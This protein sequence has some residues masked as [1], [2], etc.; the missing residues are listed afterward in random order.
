ML[1][2]ATSAAGL[3]ACNAI[4]GVTDVKPRKDD[5]GARDDDADG[6]SD[7][8]D[9]T[10][11]DPDDDDDT[12]VDRGT[13]ALGFVHTCARTPA[14]TVECWGDNSEGQLGDGLPI[15][16]GAPPA[17]KPR[18][19]P[20]LE[21]VVAIGAGNKHTCAV[22]SSGKVSCWGINLAGQLGDGTTDH[23]SKP[24]AVKSLSN[25]T[26]V[27]GG[28]SFT[29]ALRKDKTVSCWGTNYFGQ[30]GDDTND[31]RPTPAPVKLLS[32][33]VSI[34]TGQDHACAVLENGDVMCWGKNDDGQLGIGT[35]EATNLPTKLTSL[36]DIVQV[37]AA[38]RFTCA[39]QRA[40]RVY[41]WGSNAEGQLGN[42]SPNAA[43]NPSPILVPSLGDT[44]W[45]WTGY[46]HACA[47]RKAGEVVCWGR[48]LEGQLGI[49]SSPDASV[50]TPT[51][52]SGVGPS[53]AVWTGGDRSCSITTDGHAFCW[54][55]NKFGQLGNGT[56]DRAFSAVQVTGFP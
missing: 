9:V 34:A 48:G 17:L 47:V 1:A 20:G 35:T 36:S 31:D 3:V 19:V 15:E 24:V 21:D 6:A 27:M 5:G 18:A 11:V 28:T 16:A 25:A 8:P 53:Q 14:R 50:P 46:E 4:I 2:L 55:E 42:G 7:G 54:G 45:I 40:G 51:P 38:S 33:V 37:S 44:T 49:G 23:S 22:L 43:A 56:K 29:C 30:L 52:V 26:E 12:P 13:L 32:D 41:C 10:E 39:R